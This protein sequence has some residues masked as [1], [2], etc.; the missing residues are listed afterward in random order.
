MKSKH[1][2][3]MTSEEDQA[4][5]ERKAG[6]ESKAGRGGLTVFRPPKKAKRRI[7]FDLRKRIRDHEDCSQYEE[8]L[9]EA[10]K[11]NRPRVCFELCP[12][13]VEPGPLE[14]Y[15]IG[16]ILEEWVE[17]YGGMIGKDVLSMADTED[18]PDMADTE[19]FQDREGF[20]VEDVSDRDEI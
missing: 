6:A 15:I 8:C 7:Q 14:G 20:D 1:E 12:L 4:S 16:E 11:H 9:E 18:G 17:R 10:V 19:N 5:E 2:V 13:F 3:D